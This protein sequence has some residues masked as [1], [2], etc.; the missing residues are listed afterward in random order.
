MGAQATTY[1]GLVTAVA[2]SAYRAVMLGTTVV[3]TFALGRIPYAGAVANFFFMCWIDAYV[4]YR[5][6]RSLSLT[7][8]TDT[9]ALSEPTESYPCCVLTIW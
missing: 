4:T 6:V 3:I 5:H 9:T 8:P 7:S 1:N 2:T